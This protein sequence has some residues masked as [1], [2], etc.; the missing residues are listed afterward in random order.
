MAQAV[1]RRPLIA[2]PG[3]DLG[4]DHMGF[5]VDKV[6]LGQV[7]L[8]VL[9]HFLSILSHH[10]S[11]CSYIISGMNNRRVRGR[12]SETVS[13]YRHEQQQRPM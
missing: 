12:S 10:Q 5:M 11:P 9:R 1:S 3:F 6:T 8:G 13:L 4:S 7:F 2:R